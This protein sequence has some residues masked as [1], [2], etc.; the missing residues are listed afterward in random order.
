M[1]LEQAMKEIERKD[2]KLRGI[3]AVSGNRVGTSA[4]WDEVY[5]AAKQALK[6]PTRRVQRLIMECYVGD[7]L[8][9]EHC[10]AVYAYL[11]ADP[12]EAPFPQEDQRVTVKKV[13]FFE[14]EIPL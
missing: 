9:K 8:T 13:E 5:A 3:C 6:P 7:W 1:T 14:D 12:F 10:Y 2:Q 4:A 11:P